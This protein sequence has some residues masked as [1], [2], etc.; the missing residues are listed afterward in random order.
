[1]IFRLFE[2]FSRL[3]LRDAVVGVSFKSLVNLHLREADCTLYRFP[4]H[5][6]GTERVNYL[7]KVECLRGR[8][9][10]GA[11][12]DLRLL[13]RLVFVVIYLSFKHKCGYS[14]G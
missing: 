12:R 9:T 7:L 3:S 4:P 6:I 14:C 1:M 10:D 11:R 8:I 5:N 13:L 2:R